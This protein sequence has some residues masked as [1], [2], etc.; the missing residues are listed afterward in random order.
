MFRRKICSV[1]LLPPLAL[2]FLNGPLLGLWGK[3]Q[4]Q[5]L[6]VGSRHAAIWRHCTAGPV[7]PAARLA[8]ERLVIISAQR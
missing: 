5:A 3:G 6:K 7:A 4:V 2:F 1:V 8:L